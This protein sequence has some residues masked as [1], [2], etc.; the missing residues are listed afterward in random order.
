MEY[1]TYYYMTH[2]PYCTYEEMLRD[3]NYWDDSLKDK[4]QQRHLLVKEEDHYQ[5]QKSIVK[6]IKVEPIIKEEKMN[7]EDQPTSSGR[8]ADEPRSIVI[9]RNCLDVYVS[10]VDCQHKATSTSSTTTTTTALSTNDDVA[11]TKTC[12]ICSKEFPYASYLQVHMR[13]HTGEK[14]FSCDECGKSFAGSSNLKRHLRT[15]TG[16][17]PF[18]CTV[19]GKS[20]SQ[21]G[22]L[23]Q[24]QITHTGEKPHKCDVCGIC[25][26]MKSSLT[27]H[28]RIHTGV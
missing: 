9:P 6:R 13:T 28:L 19:C 23:K 27:K 26:G 2:P 4:Q 8:Y 10:L 7:E 24:H 25:F 20:F 12:N 3:E 15:H 22:S 5:E 14:P 17:K 21:R 11:L 18:S 1:D 16:E